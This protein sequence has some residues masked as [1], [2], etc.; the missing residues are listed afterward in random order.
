MLLLKVH[1]IGF[2]QLNVLLLPFPF[3]TCIRACSGRTALPSTC[4]Q[5][6]F[7]LLCYIIS[8]TFRFFLLLFGFSCMLASTNNQI[9]LLSSSL[10]FALPFCSPSGA[11]SCCHLQKCKTQKALYR[12]LSVLGYRTY[13]T[14]R[15]CTGGPSLYVD[16]KSSL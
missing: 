7:L 11:D 5:F 8:M 2:K 1:Y 14:W 16:I 13:L 9:P 12:G 6:A 4:V 10:S 15:R 3:S